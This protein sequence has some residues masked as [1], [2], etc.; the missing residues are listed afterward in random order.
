MFRHYVWNHILRLINETCASPFPSP[1]TTNW[2]FKL[3][4]FESSDTSSPPPSAIKVWFSSSI[5]ISNTF[6]IFVAPAFF[7]KVIL[8]LPE[9]KNI[10]VAREK[11]HKSTFFRASS[12][13]WIL[14]KSPRDCAIFADEHYSNDERSGWAFAAPIRIAKD[15]NWINFSSVIYHSKLLCFI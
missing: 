15:L 8:K 13:Y 4:S 12:N 7:N 11:R 14:P 6:E 1:S 9:P 5:T 10:L 3:T 2:Y